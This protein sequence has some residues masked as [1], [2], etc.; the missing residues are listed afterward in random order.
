M[1]SKGIKHW[2][3]NDK[4]L[5]TALPGPDQTKKLKTISNMYDDKPA[6]EII[7]EL[8]FRLPV[9]LFSM[10]ACFMNWSSTAQ[11]RKRNIVETVAGISFRKGDPSGPELLLKFQRRE[12]ETS[13]LDEAWRR[14]SACARA[15]QKK[16]PENMLLLSLIHI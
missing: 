5:L 9:H 1:V 10:I 16:W 4:V 14:R 8:D 3:L 2:D 11:K 15:S 6:V 12:L 7:K 13:G